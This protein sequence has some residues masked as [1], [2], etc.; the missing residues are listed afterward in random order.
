MDTTLCWEDFCWLRGLLNK[1]LIIFC[2]LMFEPE[3]SKRGDSGGDW[4]EPRRVDGSDEKDV[5]SNLKMHF[6]YSDK[7]CLLLNY[8]IAF[9]DNK[10]PYD[11][12]NSCQINNYRMN[13]INS[14]PREM[15]EKLLLMAFHTMHKKGKSS[16]NS[17]NTF[18]VEG[19]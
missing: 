16:Q 19:V 3:C 13:S 1:I 14:W 17:L 7:T 5:G 9:F 10:H 12:A 4:T 6:Y 18:W 8:F 15:H 2:F 11:N